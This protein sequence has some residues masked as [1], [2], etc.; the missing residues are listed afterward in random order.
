MKKLLLML[1]LLWGG[2]ALGYWY[3]ND[4][5]NQRVSFR[6]VNVRRGDL[7]ATITATGTLEP[8][9]VVDVGA[10]IA[11]EIESFGE[12]LTDPSRPIS[13]GSRVEQGTVLARLDDSLFKARVDQSRA[14]VS[15]A[16]AEVIQAESKLRQAERDLDRAKKL[17]AK[18]MLSAQ[19]YDTSLAN[20]EAATAGLAVSKSAVAVAKANLE[21]A[22]VNLSHT[23]IRSPVKGVI[24]DRRVNIGQTVVASLNAPSLFLIA[25]DLSRMEI[26]ASVNETDVGSIHVGQGVG[27]TVGAFPTDTFR[28]KVSQIRLNASMSQSVV[29]Y[30]VVV[31]VNNADGKLL[32]YLT[33]R[34][35][36]EVERRTN[37]LL[38]P[39]AAL[40]WQPRVT[41]V[42]PEKRQEYEDF[43]RERALEKGEKPRPKGQAGIP[44]LLWV[45]KGDFVRPVKVSVGLTD[46][47]STEVTCEDLKDG[48]EV[49]IGLVQSDNGEGTGGGAVDSPF[50]PKIKNDKVKK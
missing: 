38:V 37:V 31:D 39:N 29:T 7:L 48:S 50:L 3:W 44:G 10:Q 1:T 18:R 12:D 27:F 42:V 14:S 35:Q 30:T 25:K 32:P 21:E 17:D 5:S 2:G 28:G 22:S 40:R 41:L 24:L 36:F 4:A 43:L 33:T 45:K 9:D 23:V 20:Y 6:T 16:E 46:G 34:L 15:R 49:V 11:A 26:W 47:V 13:Y 19:D 8:Q